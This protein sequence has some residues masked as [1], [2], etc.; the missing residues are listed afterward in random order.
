M[1]LDMYL[2][3]KIY[4]GAKYEHRNVTGKI[5]VFVD[6]NLLNV[7]FSKVS[8]IEEEAGYWRKANQIHKWFVENVQSGKDD[9][10][11]YYADQEKLQNLLSLVNQVLED[12]SLAETL[13]PRQEGFFFGSNSYDD[14][15]FEQLQET[16]SILEECLVVENELSDFYYHSSW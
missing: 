7:D 10:G 5:E 16:K 9:C 12:N 15:Y 14:W 3:K 1:G 2:T 6:G 8:Y 4:V 13:L 11:D